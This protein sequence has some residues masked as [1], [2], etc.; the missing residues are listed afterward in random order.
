MMPTGRATAVEQFAGHVRATQATT[1]GGGLA[2]A[3]GFSAG[4]V[5]FTERPL[6][7]AIVAGAHSTRLWAL[8][9]EALKASFVATDGAPAPNLADAWLRWEDSDDA[10][11]EALA[12]CYGASLGAVVAAYVDLARTNLHTPSG[13]HGFY[14]LLARMNH[15]CVANTAAEDVGGDG[16]K[17]VVALRDLAADEELTFY[18]SSVRWD[19]PAGVAQRREFLRDRREGCASVCRPCAW[20][21]SARLLSQARRRCPCHA[22]A[23]PNRG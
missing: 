15:A 2:T 9:E 8:T 13:A 7:L 4:D 12:V 14:Q 18:Y 3:R 10:E 23:P 19:G 11:A 21:P 5:V 22:P 16:L 1:G 17:R 6:L 20:R